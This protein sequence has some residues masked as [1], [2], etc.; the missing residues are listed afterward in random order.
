MAGIRSYRFGQVAAHESFMPIK[1]WKCLAFVLF[2]SPLLPSS[3]AQF[4]AFN[5]YSAGAGTSTNATTYGPPGGGV[6]KNITDGTP[7]G[8]TVNISNLRTVASTAQS[9]PSYG[10]P[11]FVVF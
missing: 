9:S 2:W 5:D 7:T 6:L 8:V 3:W 4:V 11:A 1:A 10:T